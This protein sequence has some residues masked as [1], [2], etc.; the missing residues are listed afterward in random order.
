MFTLHTSSSSS[1]DFTDP[2]TAP[3]GFQRPIDPPGA[4]LP[5]E[6]DKEVLAEEIKH[7]SPEGKPA[8]PRFGVAELVLF[9]TGAVAV[10]ILLAII[11]GIAV[12]PQ[13]GMFMGVAGLLLVFGANPVFWAAVERLIERRKVKDELHHH[14]PHPR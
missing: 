6:A 9:F 5:P 11:A 7:E 3:L 4:S 10:V 8:D 13:L 12:N 1:R 14:G 2:P